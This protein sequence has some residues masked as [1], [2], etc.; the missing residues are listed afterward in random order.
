MIAGLKGKW[1]MPSK[2]SMKQKTYT[3]IISNRDPKRDYIKLTHQNHTFWSY[4]TIIRG[5][6]CFLS[7]T[8]PRLPSS[9]STIINQNRV[10]YIIRLFGLCF[11]K[12]V[13]PKQP[14]TYINIVIMS[15]NS[16]HQEWIIMLNCALITK[17]MS[18]NSLH[19]EWIIMLNCA[20]ITKIMSRN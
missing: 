3:M 14:L 16:L 17:I 7:F 12:R 6:N 11:V 19:Q 18:R 9:N 10:W 15:R 8:L 13:K 1:S 4:L 20:L 2:S 5:L